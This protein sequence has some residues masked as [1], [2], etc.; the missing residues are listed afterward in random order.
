VGARSG[1]CGATA[2]GVDGDGA[3]GG[4]GGGS[5]CGAEK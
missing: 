3:W 2:E 4:G 5:E 1:V